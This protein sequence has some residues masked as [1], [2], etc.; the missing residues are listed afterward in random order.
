MMTKKRKWND[1]YVNFGFT[2]TGINN[3]V[4]K[5]QCILCGIVFSNANL[6]PS[7]LLEHFNNRHGGADVA[8]QDV[9]S[10]KAKRVR[11]DTQG[12]LPKLGFIPTEKPLLIASYHVAYKIS[13][14]KKPHTIAEELIKPCALEMATIV[15]GKEASN[16]LKLVP[17]SN[18][19]IQSRINDMSLDIL[20]QVV[21]DIRTSPLKISLQLDE[22]TDVT[23]CSQLIVFVRYIHNG[24][25]MEDFLFCE[26]LETTTR[27]KDVFQYV[28]NFFIKYDLD[29]KIIGS[30]CT[31]GAPAML[32]NKSGFFALMKQ[33][34]PHLQGTHC[35]LHRHALASKTLPLNMK[36]V[37]DFSLKIINY[38]RGRSLNHRLFKL[39]CEELGSEHSILLFNT[40]VR[41]LS[42][43]N[44]L[45]RFFELRKEV[46]TFL[47][48][49]DYDLAGDMESQEFNQMLAYLSDIFSRMNDLNISMQG[50]NVNIL[51]CCEKINSFKEKL[52]LWCRRVRRGNL[53]NFSSLEE[54]V[55]KNECLI[56]SV[57]NEILDHLEILSKSLD[58]YF[59]GG[60]LEISKTW[61]I[62]PYSFNLD[63]MSDD[64]KLKDDILELRT[65]RIL[66][67]QFESDT[68]EKYWCSTMKMF[69]KLSEIALSVLIPFATTYLC[70]SGF[71]ALVS[72][73]TK[74]R[75]RLDVQSDM[76][77]AISSRVPRFENI[78]LNKQEQKS[79]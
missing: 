74:F 54:M 32:G 47:K 3:D 21:N 31:D 9:E 44:A 13:K 53:S 57:S 65:N 55:D 8:S 69:P 75:N 72:I 1:N 58:G 59:K 64:D 20:D 27:G 6:K 49:R 15:L 43:G 40:D 50:E 36:K 70:E 61:I 45:M 68:L 73:K 7:K 18:N 10:L 41:W 14:C 51:T 52:Q 17:L 34:I 63:N 28:K 19:I 11:F 38:I 23:N 46:Q 48:E 12:T 71:S 16:K 5:P 35:F 33:E 22:T 39:F 79:H 62:N 24:G 76:R 42:R 26:D 29:I 37:L 66:A 78:L 30:V 60:E 2:C 67:M 4:Q 25:I 77:I 56:P